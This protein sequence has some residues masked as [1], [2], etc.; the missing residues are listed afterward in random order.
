MKALSNHLEK[1]VKWPYSTI[2]DASIGI[3]DG[4]HATPKESSE[5]A[6]YLGIEN[7]SP[8]GRLDFTKTKFISDDE[9]P[10]WTKR[11]TPQVNDVVFS[12]EATLHRYAMI[13]VGF[14]GCLG[15]RMGLVRPNPKVLDPKYLLYVFL[16]PYWRDIVTSNTQSG[17][18]VDRLP[19]IKFPSLKI[20]LPPLPTQRRIADILS[21]YDDLIEANRRSIQLLEE[22]A[23]LL[24]K[25]WFVR[26][27]FPN[28]EKVKMVDVLPEGWRRVALTQVADV[29]GLNIGKLNNE[30]IE[31]IDISSVSTGSIDSSVWYSSDEAPGRAKRG[32]RHTDILWSCVRPNRKSY[33]M[34]W[35]PH[36][37]LVA[38]T[39]FAVITATKVS[40]FYLYHALTTDQY[41]GYLSNNAGGAVYPAVTGKVFE[42]SEV[43]VPIKSVNDQFH[44][45]CEPIFS[46]LNLMQSQ[47]KE[48]A[49]ARD[50]ILPRLMNG[51]LKV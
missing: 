38:S 40:A 36:S 11:V 20:P 4:P 32:V 1:A 50:R 27:R 14:R 10:K 39:G 46:T 47:S 35:N 6:T 8:E 3:F 13:P 9:L 19:L 7:V 51:T 16:S 45:I 18:T 24:Y 49:T 2:K 25:E 48:L 31:Y 30:E 17:A 21:A 23:R 43:L 5:G 15:R 41:V 28:H 34:V 26:F 44:K 42:S 37:R 29:N 33:A 22:S 12:Y